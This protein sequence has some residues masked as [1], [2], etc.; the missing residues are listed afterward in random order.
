MSDKTVR[1]MFNRKD[2]D[3]DKTIFEAINPSDGSHV[4]FC[5]RDRWVRDRV[6]AGMPGC[7]DWKVVGDFSED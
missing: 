6:E 7:M 2:V 1:D 5:W 3:G 4:K